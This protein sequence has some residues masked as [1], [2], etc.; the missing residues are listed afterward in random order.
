MKT[1]KVSI[2]SDFAEHSSTSTSFESIS[3]TTVPNVLFSGKKENPN[4]KE[5]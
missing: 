4:K 5:L 2:E 3:D 1:K